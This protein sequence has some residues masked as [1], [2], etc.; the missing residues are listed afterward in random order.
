GAKRPQDVGRDQVT[1]TVAAWA[2]HNQEVRPV[3]QRDQ[4]RFDW[5]SGVWPRAGTMVTHIHAETAGAESDDSAYEA[6]P[7]DAQFLAADACA[8][9]EGFRRPPPLLHESVSG[10]DAARHRQYERKCAIGHT[11][12]QDIGRC[13]DLHIVVF[14]GLQVESFVSDAEARNN[15]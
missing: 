5:V 10:H 4:I 6:K 11:V 2:G 8:E 7:D 13:A 3:R 1:S 12:I 14:G 15:C 9:P